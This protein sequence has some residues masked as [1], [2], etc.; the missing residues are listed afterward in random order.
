MGMESIEIFLNVIELLMRKQ[1]PLK[2]K[3]YWKYNAFIYDNTSELDIPV[4]NFLT[5]MVSELVLFWIFPGN[6]LLYLFFTEYIMI[7]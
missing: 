2:N 6:F 3:T 7:G 4:K 5:R 1:L